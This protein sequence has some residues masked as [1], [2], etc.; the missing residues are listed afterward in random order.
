MGGNS[1]MCY[2][3]TV[4]PAQYTCSEGKCMQPVLVLVEYDSHLANTYCCFGTS[5][6]WSLTGETPANGAAVAD[7][8]E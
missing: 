4:A 8:S 2:I 7:C 1:K 3:D 6:Q 5:D